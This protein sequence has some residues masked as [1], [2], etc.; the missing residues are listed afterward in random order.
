MWS[1]AAQA[2]DDDDTAAAA[3]AAAAAADDDDDNDDDDDDDGGGFVKEN[4]LIGKRDL[5]SQFAAWK[6]SCHSNPMSLRAT[7]L[8]FAEKYRYLKFQ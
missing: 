2:N 6:H 7:N 1:S 8:Q 3:T 4:L 5:L